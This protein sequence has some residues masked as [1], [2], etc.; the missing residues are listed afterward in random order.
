MAIEK[1]AQ[2][3]LSDGSE[4]ALQTWVSDMV[5]PGMR[6]YQVALTDGTLTLQ[7]PTDYEKHSKEQLERLYDAVE[8]REGLEQVME[9]YARTGEIIF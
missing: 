9:V 3:E 2:K 5:R 6:M 4:L 8:T 7:F 1:I